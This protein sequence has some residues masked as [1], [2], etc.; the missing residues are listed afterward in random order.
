[1]NKNINAREFIMMKLIASVVM[2]MGLGM[3]NSVFAAPTVT[4]TNPKASGVALDWC[5]TWAT[6]CGKPAADYF[7]QRKGHK[8]SVLYSKENN[9]GYTRILK[10]GQICNFP[11]CDSFKYI[12]CKKKSP[13]QFKRFTNPKYQ[14]VALD[15]CYTWASNCGKKPA[16]KFCKWKGYNKGV[17][18]FKKRNNIGYTKIMRTGQICNSPGCDTYRYI[19]CKR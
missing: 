17:Y 9:I 18:R 6:N 3:M 14:G 13:V 19:D 8:K 2:M 1:M 4:Y 11:G 5:K 7:C 10:T 16:N 15:W 12:K